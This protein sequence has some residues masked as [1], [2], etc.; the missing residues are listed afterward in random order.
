MRRVIIFFAPTQEHSYSL[1]RFYLILPSLYPFAMSQSNEK[2][3]FDFHYKHKDAAQQKLV[4]AFQEQVVNCPGVKSLAAQCPYLA[5]KTSQ[6]PFM[7]TILGNSQNVQS[8]NGGVI[9]AP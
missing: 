2:Q 5:S 3:Q 9:F 4:D 6:C 1:L 7:N 8:S